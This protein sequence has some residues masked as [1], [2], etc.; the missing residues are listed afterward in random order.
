MLIAIEK[1]FSFFG[2]Y[3]LISIE[4]TVKIQYLNLF[5]HFYIPLKEQN[6]KKIKYPNLRISKLFLTID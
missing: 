6:N 3:N 5:C 1:N 2:Y 4:Y